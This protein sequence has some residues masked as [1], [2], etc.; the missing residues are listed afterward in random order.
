MQVDRDGGVLVCR[1]CGSSEPSSV[2]AQLVEVVSSSEKACPSC[3]TPLVRSKLDG[4]PFLFCQRC[5]GMLI[6]ME[7]FVSVID[8]ARAHESPGTVPPRRQSPGDRTLNC[9]ECMRPMLSHFYG[10]PG[11]LVIDT[12]ER[13]HLNWLDAGELR[14]IARASA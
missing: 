5:E 8:A 7:Y 2:I 1:H 3:T 10:G 9:P 12:C 6:E 11:N 13:C 4:Q 14:R